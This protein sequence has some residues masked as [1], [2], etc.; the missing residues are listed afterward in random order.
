MTKP[1]VF[2]S[3][4]IPETGMKIL[5][6][7]CRVTVNEADE[8]LTK[9]EL[10]QKLQGKDGA[11]V[12]LSDQIDRELI[13]ACPQLKA[14]SNLAVGYNNIDVEAAR[15]AGITATNVPEVLTEA[16][17]DLTWALLMAVGRRIVEADEYLRAGK[18]SSWGPKLLL[19]RDIYGKTLGIIGFGDIGKA[20]GKRAKGFDMEVL[21]NKRQPLSLTK[22]QE[23]GVSYRELED[24]LIESDYISINAPLNEGTYHLI[25]T[26]EL[27]LMKESAYL[28]NTGR[29]P[30]IDEKALVEALKAGEIAGAGLDVFENEPDVEPGLLDMDNV[31]LT[32]HIGSASR[33]ARYELA[34]IAAADLIAALTDGEVKNPVT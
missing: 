16:T 11:L 31:V 1:E 8:P 22:E 18:F 15:K 4:V 17:A 20:V 25:G 14:V 19:G 12:M 30:I 13:A 7:H 9:A 23:L 29:G 21:Y 33:E 5:E 3:R 28:I 32:P 10:I 2:V 34:E 27:S 6:E 26:E 24:L